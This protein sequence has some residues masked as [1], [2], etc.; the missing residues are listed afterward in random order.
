MTRNTYRLVYLDRYKDGAG[1]VVE[2]ALLVYGCHV[3]TPP[4][5]LTLPADWSEALVKDLGVLPVADEYE[6]AG[7]CADE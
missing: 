6:S 3:N 1:E 4:P 7:I 5:V 2:S